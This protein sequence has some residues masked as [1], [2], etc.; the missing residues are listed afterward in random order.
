MSGANIIYIHERAHESLHQSYQTN[1]PQPPTPTTYKSLEP[2]FRLNNH[3]VQKLQNVGMLQSRVDSHLFFRSGR[4]EE[5]NF[6]CCHAVVFGFYCA[7]YT[8][9]QKIKEDR[10]A[11]R[12]TRTS[13]TRLHQSVAPIRILSIIRSDQ[14]RITFNS[15]ESSPTTLGNFK[16]VVV[17]SRMAKKQRRVGSVGD[18]ARD[19]Q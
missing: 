17:Q 14:I 6:S 5:D 19:A 1:H 8:V 18:G 11:E 7:V 15:I 4:S 10:K 2:M 12:P 3:S 13:K 9:V 16:V